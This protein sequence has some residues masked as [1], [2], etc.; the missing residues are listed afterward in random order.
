MKNFQ[1]KIFNFQFI[2][3]SAILALAAALTLYRIGDYMTFLGD[4]GRDALVVYNILHG[5]LTLLGPTSSVGGF[6]LGP[7][8]YYFSAPF[9]Y[10]SRLDPVGPAI[11]VALFGIAT[12]WLVY[13]LGESV[14]SKNVGL[15]S[16]FLYAIS[17]TVITYSRSSWNPN[18]MPFFT[19]ATLLTLFL[20]LKKQSSKLF[21]ACGVF[22]GILMQLHYLATFVGVIV[23]VYIL[24]WHYPS[25]FK[26]A[27]K[28]AKQYLLIFTGFLI[29][30]APFIAFE[31][32][33]SFTNSLNILNFIFNSKDT[34]VGV[35][36]GTN[37]WEVFLRLF[38]GIVANFPKASGFHEYNSMI[39]SVWLIFSI[40]LGLSAIILFTRQTRSLLS[41]RSENFYQK[42]LLLVWLF[43]GIF[44]FAFYK[45]PI[46]DYYLEFLYPLAFLLTG[47]LVVYVFSRRNFLN[48]GKFTAI[49][50]VV[51][52]ISLSVVNSPLRFF[53]NQ[54]V[55]Q[56][57]TISDFV[58]SQTGG[59]P[60]NFGL[61]SGGNSDHAYRYFF[62]LSG[63][64]PVVIQ[65]PEIDP[66]RK[67]VTDQLFVICDSLPCGPLGHS[68]W[69]IAGFG[70]A[71]IA[72]HWRVSVVEVY[73]LVHYKG[74]ITYD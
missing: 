41:T 35:Q 48:L 55:K 45:K 56:T 5:K 26:N 19:I 28:I 52:L 20:A 7:I 69:E 24:L 63:R 44:F 72:G 42:L 6:F 31:L 38:G 65:N 36:I 34:G 22:F 21:V 1:F 71:E 30:F 12:V 18:L 62:K 16:A 61:I 40:I 58:L 43:L 66:E 3:L 29:G 73:K 70:R 68:L 9:L 17:P 37:I 67:S 46:Y 50:L 13:K 14:F 47:N 57:K 23:A 54:Q 60:F 10:L 15:V 4:E 32:R 8:Y 53:P 39:L 27:R 59:K 33:H 64:D 74:K 49:S 2:V 11:M 25:T 51:V